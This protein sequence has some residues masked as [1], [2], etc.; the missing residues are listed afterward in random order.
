[1]HAN[2]CISK[3]SQRGHW[4][5]SFVQFPKKTKHA[6][7]NQFISFSASN[8]TLWLINT[9]FSS[10]SLPHVPYPPQN[11]YRDLSYT[12]PLKYWQLGVREKNFLFLSLN[13][14]QTTHITTIKMSHFFSFY[15]L[16]I[17][18]DKVL[19][20]W[21]LILFKCSIFISRENS[22]TFY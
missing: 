13:C 20:C 11:T 12:P 15:V 17:L 8:F 16:K 9:N 1:M 18:M 10:T 2:T 3:L 14:H 21:I 19:L 7:T 6:C 22:Q 4:N 5:S